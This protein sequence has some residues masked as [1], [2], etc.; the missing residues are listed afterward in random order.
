MYNN[1]KR[2]NLPSA[3]SST[4]RIK[5]TTNPSKTFSRAKTPYDVEIVDIRSHKPDGAFA[6]FLAKQND[7]HSIWLPAYRISPREIQSYIASRDK[8]DTYRGYDDLSPEQRALCLENKSI[9]NDN[10]C[11]MVQKAI[12][13]NPV[14]QKK[15]HHIALIH[16]KEGCCTSWALKDIVGIPV[17]RIHQPNPF[18]FAKSCGVGFPNVEPCLLGDLPSRVQDHVFTSVFADFTG[19][20]GD[21]I[22]QLEQAFKGISKTRYFVISLTLCRCRHDKEFIPRVPKIVE[23]I[24]NQSN[25]SV[26]K[27]FLQ[28]QYKVSKLMKMH[29]WTF[30]LKLRS[31]TPVPKFKLF[32]RLYDYDES[33]LSNRIEEDSMDRSPSP[34]ADLEEDNIVRVWYD[35]IV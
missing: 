8:S 24:A 3:V 29:N 4:K 25:F 20:C 14:D 31:S 5:L 13:L 35:S 28:H 34:S 18:A 12:Q 33:S 32:Q 22:H 21:N 15:A 17:K 30:L 19:C 9:C 27:P 11:S 7:N 26:Q 1:L 6:E 23:E 16:P 10:H 2:G